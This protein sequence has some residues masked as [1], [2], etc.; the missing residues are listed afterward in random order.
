MPQSPVSF[1]GR[2]IDKNSLFRLGLCKNRLVILPLR[3]NN[4][5]TFLT[6][7]FLGTMGIKSQPSDFA[8]IMAISSVLRSVWVQL[9][10]ENRIGFSVMRL[11]CPGLNIIQ[12]MTHITP[13]RRFGHGFFGCLQ[14]LLVFRPRGFERTSCDFGVVSMHSMP[15]PLPVKLAMLGFP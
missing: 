8:L 9:T 14:S 10:W 5:W 1:L 4:I 11:F 7:H 15:K 2:F 6:C 13:P 12:V 3:Y